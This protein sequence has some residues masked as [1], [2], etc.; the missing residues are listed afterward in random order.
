MLPE[1]A[2]AAALAATR[3]RGKLAQ[4]EIEP[5]TGPVPRDMDT[6]LLHH[7]P[8]PA[9]SSA[10]AAGGRRLEQWRDAFRPGLCYY[11][12]GPGFILV[13]DA[14][15]PDGSSRIRIDQEPLV[16]AFLLAD[17][18]ARMDG[19]P[20][21]VRAALEFLLSEG[22]LLSFGGFVTTAPYRMLRWPIPNTLGL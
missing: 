16:D 7:L 1:H 2:E 18:P 11:R 9:A 14:R 20:P 15:D 3:A 12:M 22:L 8:P 21:V 6:R 13:V 19:Q 17:Q 4:A 5:W 10:S